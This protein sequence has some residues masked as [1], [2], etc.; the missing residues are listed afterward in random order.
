MADPEPVVVLFGHRMAGA[1]PTGVGRHA[2][3]L[4]QAL[5]S[6][7][8]PEVRYRTATL[9]EAP[10]TWLPVGVEHLLVPGPR[11]PVA[12]AWTAA[13]RP[14]LERLVTPVDLVHTLL[15]W[16]PVPTRRPLVATIHDLIFLRHPEWYERG[17]RGRYRRALGQVATEADAIVTGSHFVAEDIR[18][19]LGV[20]RSR[21]HV[22]HHGVPLAFTARPQPS[23]L[24]AVCAEHGLDAGGYL[25]GVGALSH[26]KN[27]SIVA[28]ALAQLPPTGGVELVLA[29]PEGAGA[30][31]VRAELERLGVSGRTRFTGFVPDLE[32]V[33]LMAGACA[34]VHASSDEGFGYPPLEAMALG[35]PVIAAAAGSIPEIVGDGGVLLDL[36]DTEAWAGAITR[37]RTDRQHRETLVAAGRA[38]AASFTADREAE[39]VVALHRTL[40]GRS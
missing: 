15:T 21:V 6:A 39:A 19:S 1:E 22:I 32:L 4:V 18:S 35:T 16:V 23:S 9:R 24:A 11:R 17:E 28:R 40:L 13:G 27:I 31:E 25:L 36:G 20:E 12:L 5:A 29:G 26:R 37:L 8:H 33:A 14:R 2:A 10:P 3:E 38:R 30:D 7:A 34:L